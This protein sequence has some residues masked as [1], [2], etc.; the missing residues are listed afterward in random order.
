MKKLN[1]KIYLVLLLFFVCKINFAQRYVVYS[2]SAKMHPDKNNPYCS[3]M[4]D[5]KS[6]V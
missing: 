3:N 6:V 1:I 4:S 5:R 2:A